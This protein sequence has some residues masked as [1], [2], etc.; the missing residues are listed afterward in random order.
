M[1]AYIYLYILYIL[2]FK[3]LYI[4]TQLLSSNYANIV[5]IC[6]LYIYIYKIA[7]RGFIGFILFEYEQYFDVIVFILFRTFILYY[8]EWLYYII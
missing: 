5:P 2:V 1:H 4:M 6:H 3:G 7:N 8:L